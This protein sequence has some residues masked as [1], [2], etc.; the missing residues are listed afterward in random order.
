MVALHTASSRI[1]G[2]SATSAG[3]KG[4]LHRA[5]WPPNTWNHLALLSRCRV[6]AREV[7][8]VA[9]LVS[10]RPT[11]P[12]GADTPFHRADACALVLGALYRPACGL[13]GRLKAAL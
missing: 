4:L 1:H 6:A 10:R 2:Q 7:R 5:A 8:A 13:Y 11:K 3:Y 9:K 12:Y